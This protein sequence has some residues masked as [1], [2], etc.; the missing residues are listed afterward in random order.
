MLLS[1]INTQLR[2][3]FDDLLE[4]CVA[5]NLDINDITG[6]LRAINYTYDPATNQF[7]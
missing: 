3:Q 7:K 5:Y 2:D 6:K 4:L 1:F